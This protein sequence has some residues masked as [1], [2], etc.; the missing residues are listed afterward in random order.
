MLTN[1]LNFL[2]NDTYVG[3]FSIILFFIYILIYFFVQFIIKKKKSIFAFQTDKKWLEQNKDIEKIRKKCEI[4]L[5]VVGMLLGISI[6][7]VIVYPSLRA[8]L[9]KRDFSNVYFSVSFSLH[10][11]SAILFATA[12]ESLLTSISPS[13]EDEKI[14][15]L[16]KFGT[17]LYILGMGSFFCSI[18]LSTAIFNGYLTFFVIVLIIILFQEYFKIRFIT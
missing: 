6:A 11:V 10:V 18:I 13:I 4:L 15:K 5:G 17:L 3:F 14:L 7:L 9:P 1:I 16:Q 2:K 8:F 12:F